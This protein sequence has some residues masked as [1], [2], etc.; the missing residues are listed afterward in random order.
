MSKIEIQPSQDESLYVIVTTNDKGAVKSESFKA[1]TALDNK[2]IGRMVAQNVKTHGAQRQAALSFLG[3]V[4][5]QPCLDGFAGQGDKATGKVSNEFKS[6][7]RDAETSAVKQLVADGCIKLPGKG[8]EPELQEFLSV[9]RDD[10]NY[11]NAKV[12]TNKYFAFCASSCVTKGGF[13]VPV[14]VMQARVKDVLPAQEK[15]DSIAGMFRS[16]AEKLEK[17]TIESGDAIES[18]SLAR[19]LFK[20]LEGIVEYNAEVATK[21]HSDGANVV[22]ATTAAL[23]SAMSKPVGE[24]VNA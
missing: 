6:A 15:D 11:S 23:Q 21:Q 4:Y 7:V 20:T 13:I 10:K 9:L 12:T 17:I 16:I 5:R 19:T 24:S 2:A 3:L 14:P 8:G 1:D 22:T 18:L